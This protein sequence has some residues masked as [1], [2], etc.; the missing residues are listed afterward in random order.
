MREI[1]TALELVG[2]VW[3]TLS[4]DDLSV[5]DAERSLLDARLADMEAHPDDQPPCWKL[6]PA[7]N[8]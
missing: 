2:K 8:G 3:D 7:L 4:P 5:T 6:R 1:L